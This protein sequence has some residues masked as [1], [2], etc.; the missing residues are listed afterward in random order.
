VRTPSY[1]SESIS[2]PP[3]RLM[4]VFA[5][6]FRVSPV[7][8]VAGVLPPDLVD[9]LGRRGLGLERAASSPMVST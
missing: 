1:P 7:E 5:H 9:V 3:A 6:R 2:T 8:S 4:I